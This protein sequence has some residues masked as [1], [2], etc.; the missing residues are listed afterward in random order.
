MD[1]SNWRF[2]LFYIYK[3]SSLKDSQVSFVVMFYSTVIS[4][5]IHD[6]AKVFI[7]VKASQMRAFLFYC[8]IDL[9]LFFKIENAGVKA[10]Y[11]S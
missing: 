10:R 8:F 7:Q 1:K 3:K 2:P 11:I 6:G 5:R 9:K 4:H